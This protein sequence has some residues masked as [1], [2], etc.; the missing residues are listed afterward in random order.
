MRCSWCMTAFDDV[1]AGRRAG[2]GTRSAVATTLSAHQH[3]STTIVNALQTFIIDSRLMA[4]PLT[5]FCP[6]HCKS[7]RSRI[8]VIVFRDWRRIGAKFET[9]LA[10]FRRSGEFD[11]LQLRAHGPAPQ[12]IQ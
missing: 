9:E 4:A 8:R 2:G 7:Q 6:V 11:P 12:H 3:A 1:A 10:V 5:H